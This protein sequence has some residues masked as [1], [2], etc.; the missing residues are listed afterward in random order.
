VG[1]GG[2]GGGGV[3]RGV[4]W[5]WCRGLSAGMWSHNCNL[6]I[7]FVSIQRV[8]PVPVRTPTLPK[9]HLEEFILHDKVRL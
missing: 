6:M 3:E 4:G 9:T 5:C 8:L 1:G 7:W 2:V